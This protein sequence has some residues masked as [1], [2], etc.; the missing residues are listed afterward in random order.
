[1]EDI[2]IVGAGPVGSLLSVYLAQAGFKVSIY[3][4]NSD[5]RLVERKSK[6]GQSVNITLCDRG[7][8]ALE[9]VGISQAVRQFS[10]PLYNRIIHTLDGELIY[11]PYGNNKEALYAIERKYLINVLLDFVESHENINLYFNQKCIDVNLQTVTLKLQNLKTGKVS[12]VKADRLLAA[13]GAY[14]T[15]RM[16]MQKQKHFNYSQEYNEQGYKEIILPATPDG[17]W[18][19][20]KNALHIWPRTNF[21]LLGFPNI[22]GS[23]TL[24]LHMPFK[25]EVSHDSIKSDADIQDFFKTYFSDIWAVVKYNL[26]DY[27]TKPTQTMITIKCFPWTYQG[28]VAL[29]GDSCHAILPYYGQ[30][31]NAGFED[32]WVLMECIARYPGDWLTIFKQYET[33][34]KSNMDVIAEL[35]SEHLDTLSQKLD[36]AKFLWRSKIEKK[37]QKLHPKHT[38]LYHNISFTCMPYSRAFALEQKHRSVI[39]KLVEEL[40]G[41]EGTLDELETE[42]LIS[43]TI[44]SFE[45]V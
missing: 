8:R 3:E 22:T 6:S 30:G 14:S 28:K 43:E 33:L 4:K 5:P 38:S 1:M 17:N 10:I 29:I 37:I 26:N 31:T 7:F 20:E 32:C 21:V 39:E 40:D 35:C 2:V 24:S 45:A 19:M 23:F 13:D 41:V 12:V 34:R 15:V 25:G 9:G 11:Q 36:D 18:R 27:F 42:F 16:A 44:K